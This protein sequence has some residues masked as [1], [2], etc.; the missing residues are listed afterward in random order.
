MHTSPVKGDS[1]KQYE[2]LTAMEFASL[3]EESTFHAEGQKYTSS[4]KKL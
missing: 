3:Q 1:L 4:N 2:T